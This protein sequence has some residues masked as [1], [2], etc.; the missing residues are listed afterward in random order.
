M[1]VIL[2]WS[3]VG[4]GVGGALTP[5]ARGLTTTTARIRWPLSAAVL[6]PATGVLFGL[7]AWRVHPA[8]SLI[9]CS[10]F[11]AVAVPLA[12][13]DVAEQRLP[14]ALVL[15]VYPVVLAVWVIAAFQERDGGALLR[16]LVAMAAVFLVFLLI[17]LVSGGLG[18]GDVRLAGVL[19]LV[20]GWHSWT[21]VIAGVLLGL[22]CAGV[23]A[24]MLIAI[25]RAG[26]RTSIPLGPAL[27]AGTFT[28]LLV[29]LR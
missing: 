14:S 9:G 6:I 26:I 12:A 16:S 24:A 7:V 8:V 23:V 18:A 21:A 2:V 5:L 19:G 4:F 25:G 22:A 3:A 13:I 29:P 17:A 1:T 20:L 15:P 28:A 27:I 11:A 10:A